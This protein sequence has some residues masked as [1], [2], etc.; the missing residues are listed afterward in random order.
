[1]DLFFRQIKHNLENRP[2]P[3]FEESAWQDLQRRLEA[4]G[5]DVR[6]GSRWWPLLVLL[7]VPSLA[8]N[9]W[10][11]TSSRQV[12]APEAHLDT[13]VDTIFQQQILVQR[14]TIYQTRTFYKTEVRYLAA[15]H[16][17]SPVALDAYPLQGR[18]WAPGA[19]GNRAYQFLNSSAGQPTLS[20]SIYKPLL[21]GYFQVAPKTK[22]AATLPD[23][24]AT[25]AGGKPALLAFDLSTAPNWQPIVIQEEKKRNLAKLMDD[26]R[27]RA[28]QLGARAGWAIPA[29]EGLQPL[30]GYSLGLEGSILFSQRLQLRFGGTYYQ[31]RYDVDRMDAAQGIPVIDAP[32]DE[33][34]FAKAE[35]P[36]RAMEYALGMQY[37]FNA[38]R[39]WQPFIA[40]GVA[41]VRD[42]PHEIQYEFTHIDL[43]ID[44]VVSQD[45]PRS[46]LK[47]NYYWLQLGINHRLAD[48]LSWQARVSFRRNWDEQAIKTP[49]VFGIQTGLN[50]LISK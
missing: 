18:T 3:L 27:P 1:M 33:Y 38:G 5:G 31:M 8:L 35:I 12:I 19:R 20:E 49:T 2:E 13:Q 40:L 16:V 43:G 10:L 42:L 23:Q 36:L 25:I 22:V 37:Q 26:F 39:K 41:S 29:G 47:T 21:P 48:H 4:A 45:A 15:G 46:V 7:L 34:R 28:L 17:P 30:G 50:Y 44:A 6:K 32:S 11:L 9:A 24:V 14:D